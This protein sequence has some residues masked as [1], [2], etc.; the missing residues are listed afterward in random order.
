MKVFPSSDL[1]GSFTS[2]EN[3]FSRK[4]KFSNCFHWNNCKWREQTLHITIHTKQCRM[5]SYSCAVKNATISTSIFRR[6]HLFGFLFWKTA[7]LERSYQSD[8]RPQ[9][10]GCMFLL[11][12][13]TM[14]LWNV[15][16]EELCQTAGQ[17]LLT[18]CCSASEQLLH[19]YWTLW[20]DLLSPALHGTYFRKEKT[21]LHNT[22]GSVQDRLE[23]AANINPNCKSIK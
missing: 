16:G 15:H 10:V 6:F 12:E 1:C 14:K 19:W 9:P 23:T 22:K 17:L 13:A 3:F 4:Y 21:T 20:A 7:R 18:C 5:Y 8:P 11:T 2:T